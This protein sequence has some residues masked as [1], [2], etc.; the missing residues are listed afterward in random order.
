MLASL[1][2]VLTLLTAC[3]VDNSMTEL[4]QEEQQENTATDET[5]DVTKA[6]LSVEGVSDVTIRH[7]DD[8][9][10]V[11]SF[12]Y[13]QYIDHHN[14]SKG[15]FKQQASLR[16][17]GFDKDV[18][19]YTHGY[20]M[21][22]KVTEYT[23][24]SKL[25]DANQLN[26]EHRYFGNSM[27]EGKESV[28]FTYMDADQ[29]A[30]DIHDLVSELKA[31]VFQTSKWI[32]TG[33]SKDGITTA[34]QAY[35]S[36]LYGWDDIDVFVPFCAPF[37]SGEQYGDGTFSCDDKSIGKYI[38]DVCG[39]GY[40]EGT[41][42]AIGY[43]R[44][45]LIPYY[46]CTNPDI[47]DAAIKAYYKSL[48]DQYAKVVEQYNTHSDLSTGDLTKDL[49]AFA[50]YSYYQFVFG[51]FASISYSQWASLIP[52]VEQ[53]AS[54]N[55]TRLDFERFSNFLSMNVRSLQILI[56]QNS[57]RGKTEQQWRL[58]KEMHK[59]DIMPYYVQGFK[60]LGTA[61]D[62][63]SLVDGTYLTAEQCE[64]VNYIFT[65]QYAYEGLFEQDKGMLMRNFL[66]WL[67]TEST[68]P[69]IFVYG[70]NDPWTGGAIPDETAASNPM[71]QKLV[72]PIA[73]HNDY[74]STPGYYEPTTTNAIKA[75]LKK[76]M[77]R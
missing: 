28:T 47:R 18:V 38:H 13:K 37:L 76:F 24:V 50:I 21:P 36:D 55:A 69:I 11:Y 26:I 32:S 65:I 52:D 54:G 51:W 45:R 57:T 5:D 12:T 3:S 34:L 35:Y 7:D 15:L 1:T 74:I 49:A 39:Y 4:K 2:A 16:F 62:D 48:P 33:V 22:D 8:G 64:R 61:G 9:N 19:L 75:A 63:Y 68:K 31:K 53:L 66:S 71:V 73:V 60:E 46:I 40:E 14:M 44:L 10:K 58:L 41:E 6:L 77:N 17:K 56:S 29:Q 70:Y 25:L 72:D 59:S 30:N 23:D 27:P 67:K 43:Q 42:E 20:G